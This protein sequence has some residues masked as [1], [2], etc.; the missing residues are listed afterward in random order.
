MKSTSPRVRNAAFYGLVAIFA[1]LV[2]W[3]V[4]GL[5]RVARPLFPLIAA[6]AIAFGLLGLLV[7]VLTA[8]LG[9]RRLRKVF[10][11]LAGASAA[12]IPIFAV[13]HN[14]VY[15]LFIVWFG[16]G[17]WESHG[18][19]DEPVFFILAILI[20]P[21]LFVISSAASIVLMIRSRPHT[22]ADAP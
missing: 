11:L 18:M 16:K 5:W 2:T 13:L 19:A 8:R 7:V 4:G 17:F 12:G 21:A 14:L 1:V 20:C 9:E 15:G 22:P 10:F 3:L 6:L